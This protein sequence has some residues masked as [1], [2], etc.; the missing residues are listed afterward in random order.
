MW[1]HGVTELVQ[2]YSRRRDYLCEGMQSLGW[3]IQKPKATMY[4]WA[5]VPEAFRELGSLK[6]CEKLVKETGIALSPGVGFGPE[7]EG[8]VRIS[9]VTRDSRFYDMLVR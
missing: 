6:L 7:G 3:N 2:T 5:Q 4:L 9:L 8:F 1:P